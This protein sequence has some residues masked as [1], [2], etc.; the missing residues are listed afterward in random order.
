MLT[1]KPTSL[2]LATALALGPMALPTPLL[3]EPLLNLPSFAPLVRAAK[4]AVVTVITKS[5]APAAQEQIPAPFQDFM[6]R[7]GQPMPRD[8]DGWGRGA[9]RQ[10]PREGMGSG[11]IIDANGVIVTNNHVVE[12]ADEITVILDDGTELEASL[13][14]RDEK[15]DIAVLRVTT[16][17][18][19]P[20]VAWG[21]S[22]AIDVGDWAVAIGNPLG[23]DG[24]V[25]AG[26]VSARGR[27]IRSGPYDDYIQVDVAIN[28]GN[29][30]GPL[31]DVNGDVIGVNTAILSPSGGNIGLGFAIPAKQA[32]MIVE[33]LLDDG[34]VDRGWI[35]VAIQNVTPELAEGLRL[36]AP[37]GVLVADVTPNSPAAAAGLQAGDVI[38]GY[39]AAEI[40]EVRDLTMSVAESQI[41]G[42][43]PIEVWRDNRRISLSIT[44]ERMQGTQTA[45][46]PATLPGK[47]GLL[48]EMQQGHLVVS[49][50]RGAAAEA[51]LR[52]GDVLLSANQTPLS[53]LPDLQAALG[54]AQKDGRENVLLLIERDGRRQF[55]PM[56]LS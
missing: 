39:G 50:A 15:I 27:D 47:L 46:S 51:G 30:G 19:L 36:D 22:D 41:G 49:R 2:L 3:A 33:D 56:P 26:I 6:E 45:Q 12:G 16:D 52:V 34:A 5:S 35:G 9:P 29:S 25:T 44:P 1:V 7:F 37:E 32:R 42:A 40:L 43:V 8:F 54:A 28:R 23:L 53:S 21:D 55:V 11:F 14:G 4:P 48:V 31:F 17:Q 20:V 10:A 13:V 18:D 38:L 24:T